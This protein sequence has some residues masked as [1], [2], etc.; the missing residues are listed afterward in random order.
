[1]P[2]SNYQTK[3]YLNIKALLFRRKKENTNRHYLFFCCTSFAIL[4]QGYLICFSVIWYFHIINKPVQTKPFPR[5][6][7]Q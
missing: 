7:F 6:V 1:M 4:S 2:A 3:F 5:L